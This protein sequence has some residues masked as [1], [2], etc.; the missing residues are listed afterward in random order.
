VAVIGK[1]KWAREV[2]LIDPTRDLVERRIKGEG[3]LGRHGV[4]ACCLAIVVGVEK[5]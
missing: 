2:P 5:V 4:I 1:G 3:H